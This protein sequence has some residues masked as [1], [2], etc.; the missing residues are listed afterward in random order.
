MFFPIKFYPFA[1]KFHDFFLNR[2]VR[3]LCSVLIYHI[4][5]IHLSIEGRLGCLQF[6]SIYLS[7]RDR[8]E[9][10]QM[11]ME[12]WRTEKSKGRGN[13]KIYWKSKQKT[14]RTVLW[15]WGQEGHKH[16]INSL[17]HFNQYIQGCLFDPSVLFKRRM[18]ESMHVTLT[19]LYRTV[20]ILPKT[21]GSDYP[22][23]E[24]I[25]CNTPFST[26]ALSLSSH[27]S[28]TPA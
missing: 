11:V 12:V 24:R 13:P 7:M 3:H 9:W 21:F 22:C 5:F 8:W 20:D 28:P 27:V 17:V 2:W 1:W 23:F 10:I 26:T 19:L 6:L 4:F 14:Q 25:W 16:D 18:M 15:F